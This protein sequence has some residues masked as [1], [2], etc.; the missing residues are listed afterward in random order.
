MV[1]IASVSYNY[2]WVFFTLTDLPT[3]LHPVQLVPVP[4]PAHRETVTNF[5]TR[6]MHCKYGKDYLVVHCQ[7]QQ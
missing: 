6:N 7:P 3:H 5:E 4:L 1:G 2:V